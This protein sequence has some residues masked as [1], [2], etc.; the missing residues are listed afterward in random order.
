MP[1]DKVVDLTVHIPASTW[2]TLVEYSRECKHDTPAKTV[3]M[4]LYPTLEAFLHGK[5]LGVEVGAK[6]SGQALSAALDKIL[7]VP[8]APASTKHSLIPEHD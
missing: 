3:L 5:S 4:L 6:A 8:A 2:E 1:A 7:P